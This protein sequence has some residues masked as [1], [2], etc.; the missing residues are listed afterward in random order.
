MVRVFQNV[1]WKILLFLGVFSL[2]FISFQ[3]CSEVGFK[4]TELES[5]GKVD[6]D[7]PDLPPP[8]EGNEGVVPPPIETGGGDDGDD[9]DKSPGGRWLQAN[10]RIF[11][12]PREQW[13]VSP[14]AQDVVVQ[15]Q[16]GPLVINEAKHLK[17]NGLFGILG[18]GASRSAELHNILGIVRLN[19]FEL[20]VAERMLTHLRANTVATGELKDLFGAVCLS[21]HSVGSLSNA[22]GAVKIRGWAEPGTHPARI[23][24]IHQVAGNI[25]LKDL[26]VGHIE[27]V[28]GYLSINR[29]NVDEIR[30]VR[31]IVKVVGSVRR[32]ENV[33]GPVFIYGPTPPTEIINC[34]PVFFEKR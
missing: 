28:G 8:P 3:N 13:D 30:H 11:Y 20:G 14:N 17:V 31:G 19:S 21:A 9:G 4:S 24:R 1:T 10:C 26:D 27:K 25:R 32:L 34:G 23:D 5:V 29:G 12:S 16:F 7:H 2:I 6:V 22:L 18:V 33:L 15:N